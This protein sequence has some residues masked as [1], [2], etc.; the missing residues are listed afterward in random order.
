MRLSNAFRQGSA[1]PAALLKYHRNPRRG[2]ESTGPNVNS[3]F[4]HV[5]RAV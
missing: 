5:P 2:R 4:T 3:F 1:L